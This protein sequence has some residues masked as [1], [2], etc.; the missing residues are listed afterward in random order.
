MASVLLI[1][2]IV[3]LLL[4][5]ALPLV[6]FA[7]KRR[8]DRLTYSAEEMTRSFASVRSSLNRATKLLEEIRDM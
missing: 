2:S 1:L 5:I 3:L 8:L 6:V 7:I 4:W